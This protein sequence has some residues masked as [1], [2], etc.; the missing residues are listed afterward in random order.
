[1][2]LHLQS[3]AGTQLQKLSYPLARGKVC[4]FLKVK[5]LYPL[6]GTQFAKLDLFFKKRLPTSTSKITE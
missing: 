3:G 4:G 6:R 1:M 2:G 5:P